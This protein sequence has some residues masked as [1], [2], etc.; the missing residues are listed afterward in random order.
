MKPVFKND[1]AKARMLEWFDRFR[2]RLNVASESRSVATRFGDTHVL[3]AGP[4]D[5]RSLVVLHGAMASSAHMLGELA[6]LLAKFRV[7]SVDV[8]G[9]SV[10]TPHARPSVKNNDNSRR[11]SRRSS[12]QTAVTARQRPTRFANGWRAGSPPSC[13]RR[14]SL[15]PRA[16]PT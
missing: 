13:S 15:P 8:I 4:V 2:A 1:A 3:V 5:A 12:S 16:E 11:S 9:Q 7:Y 10:K 14:A 6:P